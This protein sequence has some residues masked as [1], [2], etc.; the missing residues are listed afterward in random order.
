MHHA[1][2][3][4]RLPVAAAAL[5]ATLPALAQ[6]APEPPAAAASAPATQPSA[7]PSTTPT[8]LAPIVVTGK[9]FE[10]RA[11]D[12]PYAIGIVDED[13]IKRAGPMINLS[14]SMA[15][16]PGITV[17]S[18]NNYAQ[19]LQI[20]SRG[21]GARASFGVRGMR[22]YSDGIPATGPDGQGQVSHFDIAGAQRVEV[23][24]GPF[25]AL[26]GNSSGGVIALVSAPVRERYGEIALDAGSFG[27]RQARVTVQAPFGDEPGKGLDIRFGASYLESDGFRPHSST[28]RTLGNLRIGWGGERDTVIVAINSLDQPAEDPLGLTRA[29]F[30]ADP[31]QTAAVATQF[32][33]R[34][35]TDQ[36]Q[37]GI[38]WRHRFGDGIAFGLAESA[39]TAY[40]GQRSV[41]QWQAIP[42]ATQTPITQPGGVIDFARD[43]SGVDARLVW[44]WSLGDNRYAQLVTGAAYE[45]S[46]EDR[47]GYLNFIGTGATQQL[48]VAGAQRRNEKN[49]VRTGDGYAQGE[50]EFV[51]NWVATLGVRSGSVRFKSE[52]NFIVGANGDDSGALRFSYTNPV[53]AIQFRGVPDWNF[54]LSAGKGFESPTFGE[55]AYRPDG[56]TGVNTALQPQTSRSVELGAKW[57]D[58]A[59]GLNAEAAVFDAGT[60][61]EIATATNAGGRSTFQNVGSTT[62]RG[63]E[64]AGGWQPLKSVRVAA[65]LTFLRATYDDSFVTCTGVPCNAANPGNSAVVPAGNR[66]AGTSPKSGFAEVAWKPYASQLTEFAAE[67]RGFGK[68]AVNDR[69]GDFAAGWSTWA[70]RATH[71]LPLDNLSKGSR[72]DVL[73][74]VDNVFDKTY[75]GSVIVNEGNARFF[76]T[77]MP[78]NWLLGVKWRQAF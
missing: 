25:S 5:I 72:I 73:A 49:T 57:R 59:R 66:I 58:D 22:L 1:R 31:R 60:S 50:V 24:R 27:L 26:Y 11:F 40:Y 14:E 68:V 64:L 20:N 3:S 44:R 67:W 71:T 51:K 10:Q 52:D 46:T 63:I 65:A 15:R 21:F 56:S 37:A 2:R 8:T 43:Y 36:Q 23:L 6:Q 69:N 16:I 54:Y 76:E 41:T 78:R 38:T 74:R 61:N 77:G 32:D 62:R 7:A 17:A 70:L 12:T 29:Q 13:D 4:L 48:G 9:G 33:T 30:D 75:A 28:E 35:T 34:K 45:T 55:L 53:A 39:V 47:F 42:V 18:R 19:D